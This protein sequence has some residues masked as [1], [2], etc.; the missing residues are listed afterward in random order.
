MTDEHEIIVK[1]IINNVD[2]S[3]V[4]ADEGSENGL[5]YNMI[6]K[7]LGDGKEYDYKDEQVREVIYYKLKY[8]DGFN[9]CHVCDGH[10]LIFGLDEPCDN[11]MGY[12]YI[13][14]E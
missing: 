5:L 6:H 9:P 7:V 14:E 3:V 10:G 12:G 1:W 4:P 2:V 11:C 13:D 8:K